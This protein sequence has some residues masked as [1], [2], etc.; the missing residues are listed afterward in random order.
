MAKL[1]LW[2]RLKA[3]AARLLK[4][5]ASPFGIALGFSVGAFVVILPLYGF[6]TI[7]AVMLAFLIPRV[8]KAAVLLGTNVSLPPTVPFITWAGYDIGRRILNPSLPSLSLDYFRNFHFQKLGEFL[9]VLFTGSFVLALLTGLFLFVTIYAGMT[10]WKVGR[11]KLWG[12]K[13]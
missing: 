11:K 3:A 7:L 12:R 5:N 10:L 9:V 2:P 1:D 13:S 6:H 8:N 4:E